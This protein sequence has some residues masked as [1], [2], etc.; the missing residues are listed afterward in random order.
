MQPDREPLQ[1]AGP[2]KN[3]ENQAESLY[4]WIEAAVFSLA[5][6]ALVFAFLFRIVGVDG[7]SMQ[8]TLQNQDRLIITDLNYTPQRGDIVIINRYT[9]EPLIKRVIA[10]GGDTL[11][12]D[13]ETHQV[14]VN[15]A[16][17]DEPYIKGLTEPLGFE[18]QQVPKGEVFV[19]G[20]NRENSLD[21]RYFGFFKQSDIMGK[22][23]FRFLPL[24]RTKKL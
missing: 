20:D 2:K 23:V 3:G 18:T 11:Q 16:V 12:I 4:E 15:G 19:M 17:Q 1:E 8:D 5:F 13:G 9:E 22:A 21:S 7:E 10:V 6:V 24:G 14:I